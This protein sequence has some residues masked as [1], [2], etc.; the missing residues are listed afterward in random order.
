MPKPL[1]GMIYTC[2]SR[3]DMRG[4]YTGNRA[5]DMRHY[6]RQ[7]TICGHGTKQVVTL[8]WCSFDAFSAILNR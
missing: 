2:S 7:Q 3:L 1:K 8:F 5:E 4:N 6:A